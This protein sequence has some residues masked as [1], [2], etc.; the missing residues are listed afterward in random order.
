LE[1]KKGLGFRLKKR[2]TARVTEIVA[3]SMGKER[4]QSKWDTDILLGI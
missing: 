2:D 4:G 1:V 3:G